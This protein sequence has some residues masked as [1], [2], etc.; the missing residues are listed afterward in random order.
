LSCPRADLLQERY[1]AR[2]AGMGLLGTGL[3]VLRIGYRGC[4]SAGYGGTGVAAG[5]RSQGCFVLMQRELR[6]K[7]AIG[8]G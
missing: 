4:G 8:E 6:G 7:R 2:V 5:R 1:F 3:H